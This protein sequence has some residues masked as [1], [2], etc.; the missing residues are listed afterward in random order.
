[1][2][3]CTYPPPK[4]EYKRVVALP[5]SN[6]SN[7]REP[8]R[9]FHIAQLARALAIFRVEE[10]AIYLHDGHPCSAIKEVLEAIETPQYLRR[11]LVPRSP[12][13]KYIGLVPPLAIPS[14]QLR[15]EDYGLR[16]GVVVARKRGR[17]LV[18]IGLD[19][20]VEV[21][22]E[23]KTGSRV[24]LKKERGSWVLVSTDDVELYWGFR[25]L[26]FEDMVSLVEHYRRN[27]YLVIATSRRGEVVNLEVLSSLVTDVK[28]KGLDG[29]LILFGSWNKGL[30]EIAKEHG[31]K[32]EDL[33]DFILNTIP[34]QGTRTVRTEE[35]VLA[36][37]SLLNIALP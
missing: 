29:L 4:P 24:T 23:R 30:H 12:A 35:A 36:T 21:D 2:G 17:L 11:R 37:L 16:E 6:F 10:V 28:N 19:A 9:T 7:L 27:K 34:C 22:G 25:V 15:H 26:C 33:A 14:H 31:T 20:L 5:S 1:M 8:A 18:D 3:T 13:L 32:L